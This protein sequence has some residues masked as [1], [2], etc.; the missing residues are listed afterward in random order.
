MELDYSD[1]LI[2]P[3]R[4]TPQAKT[5]S[6][7]ACARSSLKQRVASVTPQATEKSITFL[8]QN[9]ISDRK[10]SRVTFKHVEK[11]ESDSHQVIPAIK[12]WP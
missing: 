11:E 10:K 8:N 7:L 2:M 3:V 5:P 1:Y 9:A 6:N 4:Q 12:V